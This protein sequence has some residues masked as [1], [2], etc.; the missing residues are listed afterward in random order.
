MKHPSAPHTETIEP[1]LEGPVKR[2]SSAL[3]YFLWFSVLS[4][5]STLGFVS[6]FGDNIR[7]LFS[8]SA[9][10]MVGTESRT[11]VPDLLVEEAPRANPCDLGFRGQDLHQTLVR[12][13]PRPLSR[14]RPASHHLLDFSDP[15]APEAPFPGHP[16][17]FDWDRSRQSV[18]HYEY[19][20]EFRKHP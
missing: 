1:L 6:L 4:I 10:G 3:R 17:D 7:A 8:A 16:R 11:V 19:A 9:G 5:A 18:W 20:P 2:T 15:E 13:R 12:V 14:P